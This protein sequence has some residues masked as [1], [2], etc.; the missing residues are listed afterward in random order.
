MSQ[1]V[2]DSPGKPKRLL[3]LASGQD[4]SMQSNRE[5]NGTKNH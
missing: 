5:E 3:C 1:T 4:T 2:P